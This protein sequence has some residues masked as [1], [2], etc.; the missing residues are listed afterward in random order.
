[1]RRN[2]LV[3][4]Y[5]MLVQCSDHSRASINISSHFLRPRASYKTKA[6]AGNFAVVQSLSPVLP[7]W[8]H[9]LQHVRLPCLPVS[10]RVSSNPCPL[11]Q[12]CHPTISASVVPFSSNFQSFPASGSFPMSQLFASGGQTTGASSSAFLP[13]NIQGWFPLGLTALISLTSKA[14]SRGFSS[15]TV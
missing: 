13:M 11:S 1:M 9:E 12:W 2:K 14:F 10:P 4:T 8:P 5:K 3:S 7:L 6:Q 15:T